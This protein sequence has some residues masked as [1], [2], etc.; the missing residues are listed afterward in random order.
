MPVPQVTKKAPVYTTVKMCDN[1][2]KKE[3]IYSIPI[4]TKIATTKE[5]YLVKTDGIYSNGKKLEKLELPKFDMAALKALAHGDNVI[6]EKDAKYFT[7]AEAKTPNALAKAINKELAK[8]GSSTRVKEV[9]DGD[10]S[11]SNAGV[12]PKGFDIIFGDGLTQESKSLEIN[13]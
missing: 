3:V 1:T 7:S 13:F 11:F 2:S 5:N 9:E 6:D 10:G 8:S 4:G 12:S